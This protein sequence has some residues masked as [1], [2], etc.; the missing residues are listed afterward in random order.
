MRVSSGGGGP[1]GPN[2]AEN[3]SGE[4]NTKF[5]GEGQNKNVRLFVYNYVVSVLIW[6]QYIIIFVIKKSLGTVQWKG[7]SGG[8]GPGGP[9]TA[10]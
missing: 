1:E 7:L 5:L 8:G 4:R 10:H 3:L 2:T 6:Y 9:N